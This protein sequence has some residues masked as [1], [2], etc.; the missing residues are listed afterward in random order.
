MTFKIIPH[1]SKAYQEMVALRTNVLLLP[2]GIPASYIQ[3]ESE[4]S[5]IHLGAFSEERLIGCCVLS[6]RGAGQVQLR[7]MAVASLFQGSGVGASI[8][9]FAEDVAREK[10]FNT[11]YL[12]ARNPVMPFYAKSG[13][14]VAGAEFLEVGIAHHRMEKDL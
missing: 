4:T 10:G 6:D 13:Y 11:L 1:L 8:V 5:D 2:S 14:K 7:Q 12:H 9:Q 3:P